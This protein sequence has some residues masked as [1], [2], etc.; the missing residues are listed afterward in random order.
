MRGFRGG[1]GGFRGGFRVGLKGGSVGVP[2]GSAG[3]PGGSAGGSAGVP[4]FSNLASSLGNHL[5]IEAGRVGFRFPESDLEKGFRPGEQP[6]FKIK[7]G[8]SGY[9]TLENHSRILRR[10]CFATSDTWSGF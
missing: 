4:R 5:G 9:T 6:P 7:K 3:V 1:S 2:W 8:E 10:M